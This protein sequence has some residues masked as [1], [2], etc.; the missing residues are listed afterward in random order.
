MKTR[1]VIW[2]WE[3]SEAQK[4]FVDWVGFPKKYETKIEVVKIE[5]LLKIKPPLKILD[6]GCGTGRHILE[7]ARKGYQVVGIDIAKDWLKIAKKAA[8]SQGL[9]ITFRF[10]KGSRLKEKEVYNVV[11]AYYHTLGFMPRNELNMHLLNIW[12]S[13]KKNG[14]FFLRTAGPQLIHGE[15]YKKKQAWER[16]IA[17]TFFVILESKVNIGMKIVSRLIQLLIKS[18]NFMRS[19]E[20]SLLMKLFLCLRKQVLR[21]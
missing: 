21:R 4:S 16:K 18:P 3:N 20:H 15:K 14:K 12:K 5:K 11:I 8:K 1:K 19:K 6:I 17:N 2:R 9:D 13:L 10:Q 7:F